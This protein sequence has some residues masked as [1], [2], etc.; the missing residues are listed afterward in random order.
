MKD[1]TNLTNGHNNAVEALSKHKRLHLLAMT[2]QAGLKTS[3]IIGGPGAP[4]EDPGGPRKGKILESGTLLVAILP[5]P[6]HL[7]PPWALL[8][9]NYVIMGPQSRF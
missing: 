1:V 9:P 7:D 4:R 5:S 6:G 2:K 8:G 3:S